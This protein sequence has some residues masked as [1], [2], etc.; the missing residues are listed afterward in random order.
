MNLRVIS[1]WMLCYL[2]LTC[3]MYFDLGEQEEKCL[4]EEIPGDMLVTGY[5]LVEHWDGENKFNSPHLGLTIT[6]RDPNHDVLMKKRY[7]RFGRFT[8]TSHAS[9]TH[10][11]CMQSNS[12]K[13]SV[14]AD[15]RLRIH[16]DVQMG[17][18]SIDPSAGRHKHTVKNIEY[19]LDHLR[20]QIIY[21]T[22]QQDF[23]RER[24]ET[25][26]QISEET[27]GKVLWWAVLQTTILLS[28]GFWQIK[29]LKDFLIAK[30]LV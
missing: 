21:I 23:Q 29:R 25:F 10:W 19:N 27:N 20:D 9:G 5:F 7:S 13:F 2:A 24:E 17:E 18:H 30:K 14:Y 11:L 4:I 28:V 6:V 3:A 16:F 12:T 26:R 15:A 8:F 22:R 1:L